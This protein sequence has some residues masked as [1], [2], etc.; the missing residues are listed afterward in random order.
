MN[1]KIELL[2]LKDKLDMM[3]QEYRDAHIELTDVYLEEYTALKYK[4]ELEFKQFKDQYKSEI[5]DL[6]QEISEN[7]ISKRN[8]EFH[9]ANYEK[10]SNSGDFTNPNRKEHSN[11][12]KAEIIYEN[13]INKVTNS[14]S[15]NKYNYIFAY[16]EAKDTIIKYYQRYFKIKNEIDEFKQKQS[17]EI[18][19]LTEEIKN[20]GI[21]LY[22]I[23]DVYKNVRVNKSSYD[24]SPG[25]LEYTE[26]LYH[27]NKDK[28][29]EIM[30]ELN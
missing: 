3:S 19:I 15:N 20:E 9:R 12:E 29:L 13:M 23:R 22:M 16:E 10:E 30:K 26:E 17:I 2:Q 8:I 18:K 6:I 25:E 1:I 7:G 27:R 14:N 28:L 11:E 4:Q 5:K 24:T 21:L